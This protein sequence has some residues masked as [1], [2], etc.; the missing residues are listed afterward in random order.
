[1]G[2][3]DRR[4]LHARRLSGRSGPEEC[5]GGSVRPGPPVIVTLGDPS[6]HIQRASCSN[7]RSK[8]GR[9][10]RRRAI[11]E[12]PRAKARQMLK[13][14]YLAFASVCFRLLGLWI[15]VVQTRHAEWRQSA[16]HRRRAYGVSLHFALPGLMSLLSLVDPA[17]TDLWRVAFAIV[18]AGGAVALIA[19]RGSAPNPLGA[20][21][22]MAAIVL[23]VLI[24]L[25][26]IA[27]GIVGDLQ[28]SPRPL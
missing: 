21:T 23:Y 2:P 3:R 8:G 16:I 14:F 4:E 24:A 19:V 6:R 1:R 28:V 5:L 25:V 11:M 12:R 26:A 27:P 13:D 9:P 18:A 15:I 17:S 22:Y 7:S 10:P 20:A